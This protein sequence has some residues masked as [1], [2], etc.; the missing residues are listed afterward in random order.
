MINHSTINKFTQ[1][2]TCICKI[3]FCSNRYLHKI[4]AYRSS[5]SRN[6]AQFIVELQKLFE[7][8]NLQHENHFYILAG[9]LKTK[10]QLWGNCVNNF[11]GTLLKQWL[12]N[13]EICFRCSLYSTIFPSFPRTG[14]FLDRC[15]VDCRINIRK[16][17]NSIN[18]LENVDYDS[19]HAALRIIA[20][21][22]DESSFFLI[23]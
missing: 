13:N 8:L 12:E 16:L 2:E 9:D 7:I 21:S 6:S 22:N 20:S 17:N 4:L 5:S 19:D 11:E 14:S 23:F 10:H 3:P 1:L 15:I 18:C